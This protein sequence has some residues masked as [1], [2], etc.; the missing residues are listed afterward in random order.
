MSISYHVILLVSSISLETSIKSVELVYKLDC[1][2]HTDYRRVTFDI[3]A[4]FSVTC[5]WI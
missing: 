4:G 5:I 2:Y 1:V 3:H